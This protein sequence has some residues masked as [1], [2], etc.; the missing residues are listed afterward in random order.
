MAKADAPGTG[1]LK[2]ASAYA[3]SEIEVDLFSNPL[4][5]A[6]VLEL[7]SLRDSFAHGAG[8]IPSRRTEL[9][10]S[11]EKSNS[12]GYPIAVEDNTWIAS[13]RAVAFYL[14]QAERA[15]KLFSEAVMEK[16]IA[17]MAP[18]TEA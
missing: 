8:Q 15:Y 9:L 4:L 16:Y 2:A 6:T 1:L 12:R 14:L 10:S 7:K 3:A 18:R 17:R 5:N 11:I 13:P